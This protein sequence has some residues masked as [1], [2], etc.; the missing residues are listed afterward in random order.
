MSSNLLSLFVPIATV[1]ISVIA[2]VIVNSMKNKAEL[3]K[4]QRELEQK[5]SHSLFQKRIKVY[6]KLYTLL[7]D[8]DKIILYGKQT[9]ENLANFREKI[10]DW[11]SKN[12]IFFSPTT[13]KISSRFREYLK[14]LLNSPASSDMLNEDFITL[15]NIIEYF[16]K[17]LK[18]EIGI[19]DT[20]P[21]GNLKDAEEIYKFIDD[22]KS[23]IE[24]SFQN[25]KS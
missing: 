14:I 8:Y 21:V 7:S 3:T 22:K 19:F 4:L 25:L 17:A 23:F 16:E 9:I 12:S 18:A 6:P 11:N 15:H 10:D 13:T 20:M 24:N 2:S 1:I 5:Y